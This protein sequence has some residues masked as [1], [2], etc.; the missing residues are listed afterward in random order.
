MLPK[1]R[2]DGK[3]EKRHARASGAGGW[4]LVSLVFPTYNPSAFLERTCTEVERFLRTAPGNWEAWFVCDGCTDGSA[5]RLESWAQRD[6]QRLHVLSYAPNRGK[7]YAVRCGLAAARGHWRI[8]TDVDLAYTFEDIER[9][10]ETLRGGAQVAI[11]SR[12]HPDSRL[13]VPSGLL[14]YAYRRQVQ[15]CLFADRAAAV[16]LSRRASRSQRYE[17]GRGTTDLAAPALRRL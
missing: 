15:A 7:G 17:R 16:A 8:F 1:R 4:T 10:A 2:T 13:S 6:P 3:S 5:A 12:L 11:A 14:G 9:L